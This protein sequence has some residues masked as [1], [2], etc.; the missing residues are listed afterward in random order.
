VGYQEKTREEIKNFL[1]SNE[2]ENT[3]FRTYV[4]QQRQC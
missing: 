3:A 1:E 4:M 2:N